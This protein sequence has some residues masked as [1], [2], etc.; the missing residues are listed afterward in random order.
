MQ[1]NNKW[2]YNILSCAIFGKDLAKLEWENICA[3]FSVGFLF[4]F[5]LGV[6]SLFFRLL[7]FLCCGNLFDLASEPLTRIDC[8]KGQKTAS[9]LKDKRQALLWART[10]PGGGCF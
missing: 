6:S 7:P 4:S 1:R 3:K 2:D 9:G 5:G 8:P 10:S